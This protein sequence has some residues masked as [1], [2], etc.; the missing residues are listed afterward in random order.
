MISERKLQQIRSR[1]APTSAKQALLRMREIF[2]R[3]GAWTKGAYGRARTTTTGA[4][5]CIAE[6]EKVPFLG[7]AQPERM[8]R[9]CGCFC[10]TGVQFA[11]GIDPA[12]PVS[13]LL[14]RARH[15]SGVPSYGS[16]QSFVID[17][18]DRKISHQKE[19]LAWIDDA[20]KLAAK[21]K[22]K[23]KPWVPA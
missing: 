11:I 23:L 9:K 18:N 6:G 21:E 2:S 3:P 4:G 17:H 8:I 22:R 12:G 15:P 5:Y 20:L 10:M 13:V 1:R 16:A 19:A 7:S 14:A